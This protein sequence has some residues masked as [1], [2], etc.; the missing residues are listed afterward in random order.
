MLMKVSFGAQGLFQVDLADEKTATLI[1]STE[2]W[3]IIDV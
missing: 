1:G 2:P 3:D